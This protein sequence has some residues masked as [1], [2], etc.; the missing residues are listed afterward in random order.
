[1]KNKYLFLKI[2]VYVLALYLRFFLFFSDACYGV[3]CTNPPTDCYGS[4]GV[5]ISGTC[6]FFPKNLGT[7][8]TKNGYDGKCIADGICGKFILNKH[9]LKLFLFLVLPH[10]N[11]YSDLCGDISCSSPLSDCYSS[12]G[13]CP[14]S[15]GLCDYTALEGGTLCSNGLCDGS[16]TCGIFFGHF[17]FSFSIAI[18]D[19]NLSLWLETMLIF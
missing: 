4:T 1:L 18:L 15:N 16:G 6:T 3:S 12:T 19:I 9:T 8:C 11:F 2:S 10:Y 7:S 17:H 13:T 5:C 14:S